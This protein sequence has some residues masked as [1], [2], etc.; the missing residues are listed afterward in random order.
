MALDFLL[1]R[2]LLKFCS[3]GICTTIWRQQK[4]HAWGLENDKTT[5]GQWMMPFNKE[6]Y[7][8]E[9][10][11]GQLRLIKVDHTWSWLAV[12]C[13]VISTSPKQISLSQ[14]C[15]SWSSMINLWSMSINLDQ[16]L[17]H[18][19]VFSV[20]MTETSMTVHKSVIKIWGL[21][22]NRTP[23]TSWV[24]IWHF[25]IIENPFKNHK[26]SVNF[27]TETIQSC[28]EICTLRQ[29]QITVMLLIIT[30]Y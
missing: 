19:S 30:R 6:V 13:H 2:Q 28:G 25:G 5:N 23:W 14:W 22:N 4:H 24:I 18:R 1:K 27:N 17:S 10:T 21:D 12:M 8:T 11:S 9:N 7:C 3:L 15:R 16:S 20:K 29:V 26:A